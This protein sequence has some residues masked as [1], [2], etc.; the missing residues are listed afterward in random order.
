MAPSQ[1]L[2]NIH[3]RTNLFEAKLCYND[4]KKL[5][6]LQKKKSGDT[7][8]KLYC[9]KSQGNGYMIFQV[10]SAVVR[11][12]ILSFYRYLKANGF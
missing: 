7:K 1:E 8:N 11:I 2:N 12:Y 9:E 5:F 4:V 3:L 10:I 6:L